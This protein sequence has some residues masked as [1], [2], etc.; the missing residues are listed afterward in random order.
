[1][2][3]VAGADLVTFDSTDSLAAPMMARRRWG[4]TLQPEQRKK[5]QLR[6]SAPS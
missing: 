6:I 1:M 2:I 3:H 5:K 4:Q